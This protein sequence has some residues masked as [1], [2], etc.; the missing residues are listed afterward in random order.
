MSRTRNL[1]IAVLASVAVPVGV[2]PAAH[3]ATWPTAGMPQA[4]FGTTAKYGGLGTGVGTGLGLGVA[5]GLGTGLGLGGL[6]ALNGG[7][8]AAACGISSGNEGQG[9][10]AGT[11]TVVCNGAGGLSFVGP[12]IGQVASVIGPTI[13][14]GVVTGSVIT[15]AGDAAA[16]GWG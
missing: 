15:T 4:Q 9:G 8:N 14:G 12:Q 5:G 6:G 7:A 1:I 13:I 10:T 3:A 16:N 11:E 2:A